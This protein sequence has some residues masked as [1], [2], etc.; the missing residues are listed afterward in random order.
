MRY[1]LYLVTCA[2]LAAVQVGPGVKELAE[3]DV[4]LPVVPLLGCWAEA[5]VVKAKAVVRVGRL[6]AGAAA[7]AAATPAAPAA[8]GA[9]ADAAGAKAGGCS[10]GTCAHLQCRVQPCVGDPQSV[11]CSV[12]HSPDKNIMCCASFHTMVAVGSL[13][14]TMSLLCRRWISHYCKHTNCAEI[15]TSSV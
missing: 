14:P 10:A 1:D 4:V 7:A 8:D 11:C 15:N 13:P 6:A 2:W 5:A 9:A 12:A 3:G